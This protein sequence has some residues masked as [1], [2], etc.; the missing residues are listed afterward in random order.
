MAKKVVHVSDISGVETSDSELA[1]LTILKHPSYETSAFPLTLDALPEEVDI[2][3]A[4]NFVEVEV[5]LPGEKHAKRT[6]L[7]VEQFNSLA[8]S[9]SM[10]DLI[11]AALLARA[12]ASRKSGAK[13]TTRA[14]SS[15]DYTQPEHAGKPH[16]GRIND[17]E[18]TY[19]RENLA[20]VNKR[21]AG[22]GLRTIDPTDHEMAKRYG[23]G[24]EE[25]AIPV[26]TPAP[27]ATRPI[28]DAPV[29]SA[30][31]QF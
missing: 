5:S 22:E 24:A 14:R 2:E 15:V 6:T 9:D 21:L 26:P 17:A 19:V 7:T 16:R 3:D 18:K 11:D 28:A 1:Q 20:A 12:E 30:P 31:S 4:D 13:R 27:A 25:V 10:G 8:H 23:F 29:E